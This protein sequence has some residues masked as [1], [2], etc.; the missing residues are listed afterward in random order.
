M[1]PTQG[2][3]APTQRPG[4]LPGDPRP[5]R[6]PGTQSTQKTPKPAARGF[7]LRVRGGAMAGWAPGASLQHRHPLPSTQ[8]LGSPLGSSSH[9]V[10]TGR[11]AGSEIDGAV[12]GVAV[13]LLDPRLDVRQLLLQVFAAL[14]LLQE[15]RILPAAPCSA[16]RNP[17]TAPRSCGALGTPPTPSIEEGGEALWG[18]HGLAAP[19][20]RE[21]N[22]SPS[23]AHPFLPHIFMPD[24]GHLAP[25]LRGRRTRPGSPERS[26]WPSTALTRQL[27]LMSM[28]GLQGSQPS[29][30]PQ[31]ENLSQGVAEKCLLIF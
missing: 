2:Q 4:Q 18:G 26:A 7:V 6:L 19:Q 9:G 14:L 16:G 20:P 30:M 25:I 27:E 3:A 12:A 13:V 15:G 1:A 31:S 22:P 5:T 21:Q 11:C 10:G 17:A 28:G 23:P 29:F 8:P 24:V